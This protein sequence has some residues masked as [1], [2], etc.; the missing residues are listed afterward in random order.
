MQ[1]VELLLKPALDYRPDMEPN[2]TLP[3]TAAAAEDYRGNT[4]SLSCVPVVFRLQIVGSGGP[5]TRS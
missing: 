5:S 1:Y 3:P 2:L 4:E